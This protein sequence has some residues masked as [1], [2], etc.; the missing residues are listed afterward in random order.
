MGKSVVPQKEKKVKVVFEALNGN[1]DEK[2]F[3]K[4]FKELYPKDCGE[5]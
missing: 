4:K 2:L 1:H 5:I 3:A